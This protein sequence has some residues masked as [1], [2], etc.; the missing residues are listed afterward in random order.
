MTRLRSL[1]LCALGALGFGGALAPQPIGVLFSLRGA[2]PAISVLEFYFF[3]YLRR[4][5][6]P[7]IP[8]LE[9]YLL[10]GAPALQLLY[11]SL[12]FSNIFGEAPAPQ[13]LYWSFIFSNIY[14]GAPALQLY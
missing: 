5:A 7:A 6:R 12:L 3:Q 9:F 11:W 1:T 8:V 4:G 14:G 2:R 10:C 13:P